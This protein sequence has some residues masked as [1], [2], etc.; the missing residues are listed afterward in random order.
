MESKRG[1]SIVGGV[2]HQ[3]IKKKVGN[4]THR[5]LLPREIEVLVAKK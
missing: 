5:H 2:N 3:E 1:E 4:L